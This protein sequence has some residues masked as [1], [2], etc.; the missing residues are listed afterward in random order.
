MEVEGALCLK[1]EADTVL[2]CSGEKLVCIWH[3]QK[4]DSYPGNTHGYPFILETHRATLFTLILASY[5]V[6]SWSNQLMD[7]A[8]ISS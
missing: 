3:P 2:C 8:T 6:S 1:H 7:L 5:P 4:Q